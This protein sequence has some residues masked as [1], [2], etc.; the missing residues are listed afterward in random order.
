MNESTER[1]RT[2]HFGFPEV[3]MGEKQKLVGEMF[4]SV[5]GTAT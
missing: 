5:A 2:I 1:S 4:S 3:S